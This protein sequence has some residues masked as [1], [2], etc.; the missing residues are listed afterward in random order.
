M[1]ITVTHDDGTT[2]DVTEGVQVAYDIAYHSMDWGSGF[3]DLAEME[4][5]AKLAEACRFPSFEDAL[6]EVHNQREKEERVQRLALEERRRREEQDRLAQQRL[7]E[8][9]TAQAQRLRMVTKGWLLP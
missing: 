5:V 3:L 2:V 1:R 4:A 6:R 9:Q 8:D 7:A